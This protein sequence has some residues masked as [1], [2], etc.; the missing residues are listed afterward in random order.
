MLLNP[1]TTNQSH[2]LNDLKENVQFHP[3]SPSTHELKG[4]TSMSR[5]DNGDLTVTPVKLS[6]NDG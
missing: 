2:Y 5:M 3:L 1:V 4:F 6:V